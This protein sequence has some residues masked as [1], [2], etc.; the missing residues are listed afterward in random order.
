MPS[1]IKIRFVSR[2][3]A[4]GQMIQSLAAMGSSVLERIES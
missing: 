4:E 2:F 1:A 3:R